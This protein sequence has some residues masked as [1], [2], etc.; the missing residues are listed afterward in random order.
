L[1]G[2]SDDRSAHLALSSGFACVLSLHRQGD[3]AEERSRP[4]AEIFRGE[5]F[6]HDRLNVIVDV[7]ILHI[8]DAPAGR[9]PEQ[10]C[11]ACSL[12]RSNDFC[13]LGVADRFLVFLLPLPDVIKR[14]AV[15][16]DSYVAAVDRAEAVCRFR[17]CALVVA[18]AEESL[19]DEPHHRGE[20]LV[21]VELGLP[22]ISTHPPAERR[23]RLA[24]FDDVSELR[25]FPL[26]SKSRMVA[27]LGAA[28]LVDA[29]RLQSR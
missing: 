20:N 27:I 7:S 25:I 19:I 5:V 13:E 17:L 26:L 9:E 2:C 3:G 23:K 11:A 15:A 22:Q 4:G 16:T 28:F 1:F 6:T 12:Q 8:A 18:D 10:F 29:D 14:D 21:A 24:E